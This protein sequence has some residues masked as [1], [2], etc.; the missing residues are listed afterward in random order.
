MKHWRTVVLS[1]GECSVETYLESARIRMNA[2]QL[3]RLLNVPVTRPTQF[4]GCR[5]GKQHAEAME[6][7][8]GGNHGAAGRA[9]V[10]W[11]AGHRE[12]AKQA[13]QA[14]KQRWDSVI[15]AD[16]G[17]QVHRVKDRFAVLEA[18][19][20]LSVHITGWDAQ[21]CRDA[22]EHVFA[23]WVAEFGTGNKEHQQIIE[24]ATA[25]LMA[26]SISRFIPLD[27]DEKSQ[28]NVPNL[29]GYK[30]RGTQ[31][32]GEAVTFYIL[33]EPFKAE[34][35]KSFD[36]NRV[37]RAL[38]DAGMLKKPTSGKGWQ[39]KTPR[40]RHMNNR[41]LRVYAVLLVEDSEPE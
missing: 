41:Q 23:A 26:N 17:E 21:G 30:D 3:V 14:A 34:L 4:H 19:L 29:A 20:M 8:W 11:L 40:I 1:S 12:Q 24:Q 2:G 9:W 5:D 38:Y 35:A 37:A 18:A 28:L 25:F 10:A 16:Y 22:L 7:A 32:A 39:V 36:A 13:Y 33:P 31:Q 15:P 27:F 6:S